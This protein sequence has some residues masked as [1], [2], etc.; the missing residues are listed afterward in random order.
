LSGLLTKDRGYSNPEM[1][2]ELTNGYTELLK[3]ESE[4]TA[5]IIQN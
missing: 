1:L 5:A 4:M 3:I 2:D